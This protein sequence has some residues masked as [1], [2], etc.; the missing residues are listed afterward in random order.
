MSDPMDCSLP[1]SSI[2]GI[3][4]ARILEWVAMPFSR[5]SSQPKDWIHVS[6]VCIL[7][8]A[9][10]FF[11][12]ST[13]WEALEWVAISSSRGYSRPRDWTCDSCFY[14]ISRRVLYHWATWKARNRKYIYIYMHPKVHRSIICC[15]WIMEAKCL[16]ID[17]WIRKIWFMYIQNITQPYK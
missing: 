6:Y 8:L 13:T 12:T 16:P 4:Q 9:S 1:G 11:T 14:C 10:R 15:C 17:E 5:G 3:P 7:V 2:H